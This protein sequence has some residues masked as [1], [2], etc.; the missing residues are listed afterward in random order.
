MANLISSKQISGVV[1]ASLVEGNF[2]VSG[3]SH[4]TGS[5]NVSGSI[6]A[7]GNISG[8]SF[9]GDGSTLS[10]VET[11]GR[12]IFSGSEQ[13]PAGLISSSQQLPAGIVSGAA[14]LLSTFDTRYLNT[15]GDGVVSGS[16]LSVGGLGVVSG[17]SQVS[18]TGLDNLP[19]GLVS[20]SIQ[21]L[22]STG[23]LSSSEQLPGGIISS[24]AQLTTEFDARY[25]TDLG[26]GIVSGSVLRPGGDGVISG[27]EQVDFD[28]LT[29]LPAGLVSGSIQVLA[30]SGVLSG[31][32]TNIE[33][34]NVFTS[35]I[36]TQV[37]GLSA[38]TSSYESIG[39]GI[40]SGSVLRTLDGTDVISGS[41][42]IT[43][44]GF[45]SS[46]GDTI[47]A[48]TISGSEQITALGFVS[49]SGGEN[50]SLNSYTSST[51]DR[52][53]NIESTTSSLEQR[54]GQIE[55]NTGSYDDQTVITSL[56]SYTSSTDTR[57][58][59]F[60]TYTS[61]TDQRLERI[62]FTS[63]SLETRV[64]DLASATASINAF[65][66]SSLISSS[67]QI[68]AF[69]FVSSSSEASVSHLNNFTSSAT[70]QLTNLESFT[71]SVEGTNA[72]TQ[73]LLGTNEFTSSTTIRL[74]NLEVTTS[75]FENK[76]GS[77]ESTTS[78]FQ[79]RF[80]TIESTTSSFQSR[81][82]TIETETASID[83]RLD[84]IEAATSSYETIGRS[85]VS[86][87][88]QLT[89]SYDERYEAR[90]NATKTLLSASIQVN[91]EE[92]AN[93][94]DNIVSSSEQL[95][96][97]LVSG[98]IQ[99]LGGTG[100]FSGSEQLQDLG[101]R[102]GSLISGEVSDIELEMSGSGSFK[103]KALT[104]SYQTLEFIP[105]PLFQTGST[106]WTI[107]DGSF[108]R[109]STSG[110]YLLNSNF[111]LFKANDNDR[112]ALF[113]WQRSLDNSTWADVSGSTFG[114]GSPSQEPDFAYGGGVSTT[115]FESGSYVRIVGKI[116]ASSEEPIALQNSDS[117]GGRSTV[118]IVLVNGTNAG[119]GGGGSTDL[120]S[121]SPSVVDVAND[122]IGFIDASNS[123]GSRRES[124]ADLV[125]AMAGTNITANNGQLS[126]IGPA[127]TISS[128]AQITALGFSSG[129]I[130]QVES[131]SFDDRLDQVQTATES[132]AQ[133][134]GSL[135]GES[136]S[137]LTQAPAGTVSGS[138]QLSSSFES[139]GSGIVSGAQQVTDLGFAVTSSN[140]FNGTQ[141]F[142]GSILPATGSTYDLGSLDK[143]FRDLYITS[144]SIKFV[145]GGAVLSEIKADEQQIKIGNIRITTS[146]IELINNAGN[147]VQNI[148]EGTFTD[149]DVTAGDIKAP[150]GTISGSEQ[151]T[152]LGFISS[153]DSTT[154]L[155]AFTSSIQTE[156]DGLSAETSSYLTSLD[157]NI[158]SSSAQI[159]ALGF[160]SES[161]GENTSL[162]SFTSSTDLRITN[163]E[164]TTSS[165]DS[166]LDSV[167]AATG[168][169]L[170]SSGSVDYTDLTSVPSGIISGS[171]LPG[172]NITINSGSDGF[173]ISSSAGGGA[174]VTVS[175]S[176]PGSPSEGDLWWKSNDGNLYV[177]YDGYWVISIDTTNAL[178]TGVL[179]GS[180]QIT[181]LGFVSESGGTNTSLNAYTESN[182]I[183]I[184][185]IHSFTSSNANTSLNSYTSSLNAGVRLTNLESTTSSFESRF[186]T[187]ETE[188][189]SIDS[190]LDSIEAATG[191]YISNSDTSSMTV[192]SASIAEYTS[193]WNLTADGSNHYV[194]QG[195]GF[196]GSA[197]DP[198]IYL[199]RGQKYKFTN[200]MGAH[201]FRIQTT[202]NGSAGTQYNN[203]VTNNDVSN[204]TLIFDVPMEAPN[205]LY[206]QCTA[207][208]NMGGAIF[209]SH[210]SGSNIPNGT[211]SG[212]EQITD[213]G[214][215]SG[216]SV[217][218]S[219]SYDGNRVISQAH[220]QG[221]YTSSFNAGTS[222]SIIDFLDAI[223][224][225]NTEPSI[226][227]GNQTIAEFS[228]SSAPIF[229]LEANDPEA[230]S[231][232]FGTASSY[233]DDLVRVASNGV[234]TLNALAQSSSFNTD[235][236]GGSHGHTFTAKA[237]DTFNASVEKDITIFV[238]PNAAPIFR[239][240][241][242]SG[243]QIT[244]VTAS[245]N[246]N[247]ADDT[248]VKR[249]FFTDAES[250]TITI[251]SSSVSPANHFSITKYST[252]VDIRQNTGSLDYET[253]PLYTFSLSASDE[254]FQNSQDSDAIS[255]LPVSISVVDNVNPTINNQTL[256]SINENSANGATVGN[257][258]ATD[259][260]GD[261]ITFSQFTLYKLELDDS[262][263]ASGSY[264]G[265]SQL[266]DP[267]ENPFQMN[268]AGQVTRK[269]GVLINSDLINEY[270]YL[271]TVRDAYNTASN[272][273]IITIPITDDTPATVT[274]NWSAGPYIIESAASGSQIKVNS[275]GLTGTQAAFSANQS[276]TWT[277]S[278]GSGVFDINSSGQLSI[279]THL[280]GST[281][282]SGA[283]ISASVIATNAFGTTTET[284]F[285]ASVTTNNAPDIIFVS[286]S[287]LNTNQASASSDE[288]VSI[289]FSDTE[290]D[291]IET[292]SH[293][294]FTEPSGQLTASLSGSSF[295]VIATSQL[296]GSTTYGFTASIEDEHHF[297]T[298]TE[299]Q[300]ITITQS[301][302]GTLGGDTTSYIIESAVS[303]A[304]L[305]DATGFG[306]GNASQLTV[307]YSPSHGSPSVQSFTSSNPAIAVNN[308]GNLTLALNLSGSTTESGD[309]ISTNITFDD[310]YGNTGSGSVTVNVF[311][312][313]A[314]TA[315]FTEHPSN[316]NTDTAV[317]G[318]TMVSMSISDTESDTPFSASISG[319]DLQLVFTNANSSSVGIQAT[320]SLTERVY[321]YSVSV[322]DQFGKS[323][324]YSD[325]TFSVTQSADYG[326]VY[327]YRS[328]YGSDAGLSSNY[329]AVM[330]IDATDSSTPPEIT[331]FSANDTSPMR[332]IS[333]SLGESTLSLAGG[334]Q[335]DL[336]ATLSG[337]HLD[338][339]LSASSPYTMGSTA[340]QYIIIVPSGSD[341]IGIPTSMRN[342][343]G[344][345]TAGEYVLS[346]NNDNGGFGV[347]GAA[348]HLLDTSGSVNGYDKHFVI[349]RKGHTAAASVIIR[350]TESSGSLPS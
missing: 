305:R 269:T 139:I 298:N 52:L 204:G 168:S 190:R 276:V 172:T 292:G 2:E 300:A 161:G 272:E 131:A 243:N 342:S 157:S 261:S 110:T 205:V 343:F 249:V 159:T 90:A 121:L 11:T 165:L 133:R 237:T 132:F 98:S 258:S 244:N 251:D 336:V 143:P 7:S 149:G 325:R 59:G 315:T 185:N 327:I 31:S 28:S 229:T 197:S 75:S 331:G 1:T 111:T 344:G 198:N 295:K 338:T 202:V 348:I 224:F 137:Y 187:I 350:L 79:S 186:G 17:S 81:F 127:G 285:T 282:A 267:H 247:S 277:V 339:I 155:N 207:H 120:G 26:E 147:V 96:G 281:T 148:V 86:G 114:I 312:N 25:A 199:V 12:G 324:T 180:A 97:G 68:T 37:D 328:N 152:G 118:S 67:A 45:V 92:L 307:S 303:G 218:S 146:S 108:V 84:N 64:D 209:I 126:T 319:S 330:G 236:V 57:L 3:S 134:I 160:V 321:T 309:T 54:V 166:R 213:L 62:E 189:S 318:V 230:Q 246:E 275:N 270:Q 82:G 140:T 154:S 112:V 341:M 141:T 170:T 322:F 179:S 221:F 16:F 39:S 63:S 231:I 194:F 73:S 347:E 311:A 340:E 228:A 227:S 175:D 76:F 211:V 69:G 280:T 294:T 18:F 66:G 135:E 164:S 136:G 301:D 6:N 208:G 171:L 49:E 302:T 24:S 219:I 273:A 5:L 14:Q 242:V 122:S 128:S 123:D 142:S 233:T 44:L 40:I 138:D 215:I 71:A 48:G 183:N 290:G 88:S 102:S 99:V 100:I 332:L 214:F 176:A 200:N 264:G 184:T 53:D 248:L 293:F 240:T 278:D 223:F 235:L 23:I 206:Y 124:I 78:S 268:S 308:S 15:D 144:E 150:S 182:D 188:T 29:N 162:N 38:A 271:V 238:T 35:S 46:S 316:F 259:S 156:V 257:I 117:D 192:N 304:V 239:E 145:K 196:T 265:T 89:S 91:Y 333:S 289:R 74:N 47:P 30:G 8:S 226:S 234:V 245:L 77:V 65:T 254:H 70:I 130:G 58:D 287:I 232:T 169:Y 61:S 151:I 87:S 21:V 107:S 306:G 163:I 105:T 103:R 201:P 116:D 337:S 217:S 283:S 195:P 349:G 346:Q 167:E 335:A 317:N 253:Y 4:L 95:P 94:P 33:N 225:P 326:K 310:Q 34:L 262:N 80:E 299:S 109:I 20:G 181:A 255:V 36:Q 93:L 260:E 32:K 284:P 41:A 263:V 329:P 323:T 125:N 22:G 191:S 129:S 9:I 216:S 286:S 210:N 256:S 334:K 115:F 174:S 27:S 288:L 252:Y 274:D 313:S 50:T 10:N 222:G 113:K 101:F 241:S 178:P 193:E 83:A 266:T 314:P 72:F 60:N 250:D 320:T 51:D 19:A 153:S 297:S 13:L 55:S 56:N 203:G 279:K 158:V 85:I 212:S 173:F 106:N 43:A 296:S 42:Q 291:V 177:Y 345:S 119:G 104:D 220:L